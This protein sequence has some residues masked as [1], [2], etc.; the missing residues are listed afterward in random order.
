VVP[1]DLILV[2]SSDV[3]DADFGDE[4]KEGAWMQGCMLDDTHF[5]NDK[6]GTFPSN[7]VE[8]VVVDK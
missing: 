6:P 4:S 8:P 1:G 3:K 5:D 2:K 7:Y